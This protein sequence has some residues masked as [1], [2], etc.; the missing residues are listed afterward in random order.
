MQASD[1]CTRKPQTIDPDAS[2]REAAK[3]M[4]REKVG[5]LVVTEDGAPVGMLTD[6]DA[7]LT[8]LV[9]KLDAGTTRVRDVMSRPVQ[10][11]DGGASLDLALSILRSSRLR[12][13]PVVEGGA[14]IGLLAMDDVIRLL[15]TEVGELAEALR[16]PL[17][18]AT[19]AVEAV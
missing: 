13:L 14:L 2:V 15:A 9:G 6:R 17:A 12:R 16:R 18:S 10:I 8:V 7:A 3:R 11:V 1:L 5:C 19:S 4:E